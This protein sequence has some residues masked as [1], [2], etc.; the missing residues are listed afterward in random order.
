MVTKYIMSYYSSPM[1]RCKADMILSSLAEGALTPF[2]AQSK[3]EWE[4]RG[5]GLAELRRHEHVPFVLFIVAISDDEKVFLEDVWGLALLAHHIG[6]VTTAY[7]LVED[8]KLGLAE[9]AE[10][11]NRVVHDFQG[12]SATGLVFPKIGTD[13]QVELLADL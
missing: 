13:V 5:K 1:K 2:V 3:K 4:V 7:K 8:Q 10:D 11:L 6:V 12:D 9:S